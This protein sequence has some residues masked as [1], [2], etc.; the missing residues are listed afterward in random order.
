MGTQSDLPHLSP[1][2]E[3][4]PETTARFKRQSWWQITFPVLAV[5]LLSVAAVVLVFLLSGPEGTSVV[6]SYSLIL[7][8]IPTLIGGLVVLG[9]V[10]V[11]TYWIGRLIRAI[12]PYAYKAQQGTNRVYQWVDRATDRIAGVVIA[13][14]S[15][16]VGV[17]VF[18]RERGIIPSAETAGSAD[19]SRPESRSS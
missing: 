8:I 19:G 18:L 2:V 14:R 5:A 17:N 13:V 15:T 3:R 10:I 11:L 16:L 1:P 7:V 12:P 9:L 4:N 6:G